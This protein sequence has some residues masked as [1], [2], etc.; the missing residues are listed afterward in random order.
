[1]NPLIED[2]DRIHFFGGAINSLKELKWLCTV[3]FGEI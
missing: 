1:M 3:S 2:N